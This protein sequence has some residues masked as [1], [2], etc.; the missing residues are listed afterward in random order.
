M[1][2]NKFAKKIIIYFLVFSFMFSINILVLK[3]KEREEIILAENIYKETLKENLY[4][5]YN[6][7]QSKI[8]KLKKERND[9]NIFLVNKD[10]LL[11]KDY[12]A[13]D[14]IDS[15]LP[16]FNYATNK[17][18]NKKV[19]ESAKEMFKDAKK[20]GI[21]LMAV[22]GYRSNKTQ[23]DIF[24]NNIRVKGEEATLKY[25]APPGASEHETGFAI[26][27]L[28]KNYS[29]LDSGFENTNEFKWLKENCYKYGFIIRYPKNK[30]KITKYSYEPW[31][32]RYVGAIHATK[33][34]KENLCLEE[35]LENL[36]NEINQ[37]EVSL[38][39]NISH[40]KSI[41]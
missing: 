31:H 8:K 15:N 14:I 16:F 1:K 9:P 30:T 7:L 10:N 20:C 29:R 12:T 32:Y 4:T 13:S 25:S 17:K 21:N 6:S 23:T 40:I 39:K 18:L 27:I 3:H 37:L 19:S 24:N 41:K 11:K 22:S 28:S 5:N 38:A 36:D 35:Y 34:M 26:D 33:I 2:R